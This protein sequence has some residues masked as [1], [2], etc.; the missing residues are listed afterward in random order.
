MSRNIVILGAGITGLSTAWKLLKLDPTTKITLIERDSVPGGMAKSLSWKG[1]ILDLGPHR[2]HTEIPEIREFI[3]SF[4]QEKMHRVKRTSRMYLNGNYVPYPVNPVHTLKALGV[5][6]TISLSLSAALTLFHDT[7]K[8]DS[9]EDYVRAYYGHGLY[10]RI[11]EPF[12][13]KVWGL[14]PSKISAE[15]ARVRLRGENI[16]HVLRDSLFSREETYVSEFLYPQ[17]GI[18]GIAQQFADEIEAQGGMF[19]YQHSVHSIRRKK[20]QITSILCQN[21]YGKIE[22]KCDELINTIPLPNLIQRLDTT[23]KPVLEA[24][25]HLR[26]RA[27]VLLYMLYDAPLSVPDTWLY[28]PEDNV[29]FSRI[30]VPNNFMAGQNPPSQGCLCLEFCCQAEDSI[31]KSDQWRLAEKANQILLDSGLL[32]AQPVDTLAVRLR[33]GYPI[34]HQG[35][36]QALN[37]VLDYL[38]TLK[39]LLTVG[40]QGLFRH[41]NIDQAI[42]MGLKAAETVYHKQNDFQS[43]YNHVQQFNDYRI[44]D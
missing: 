36:E 1:H 40:R 19:L 38:K 42:Q 30:S 13:R 12:A 33:E 29:P 28:Y 16:W 5:L 11:F 9:Y 6:P 27:L 2:F 39:N 22:I 31:W 25:Q 32:S 10:E 37:P 34:Y 3:R 4:C 7:S 23:P 35:Y 26:F 18:G 41:N 43:W 20:D 15:T 8:A 21:P 44:V 14:P 24:S 17:G